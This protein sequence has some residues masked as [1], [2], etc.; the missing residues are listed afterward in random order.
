MAVL[1][2]GSLI[3]QNFDLLWSPIFVLLFGPY[4]NGWNELW[5]DSVGGESAFPTVPAVVQ[6]TP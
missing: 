6:V 1:K 4:M 2:F 3:V 5:W